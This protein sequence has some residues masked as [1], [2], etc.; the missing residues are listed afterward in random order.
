MPEA[1]RKLRSQPAR[2]DIKARLASFDRRGLMGLIQD[3][4]VDHKENRTFVHARFG[5]DALRPY[6]EML[7]DGLWPD[8]LRHQGTSVAKA[9]LAISSYKKAVAE[10]KSPATRAMFFVQKSG[11]THSEFSAGPFPPTRSGGADRP[12]P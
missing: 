8:V 6:K 12:S 1:K 7:N 9:K 4:Y 10:P 3:L 2:T 5:G 11:V